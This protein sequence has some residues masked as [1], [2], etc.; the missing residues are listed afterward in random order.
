MGLKSRRT[1]KDAEK[2]R[3]GG[4]FLPFSTAVLQSSSL[5]NLSYY[6]AKLLL[7][8]ASQYKFGHNDDQSAAW[9]LMK[10]RGWRSKATLNKALSEL[11]ESGLIIMTRQGGMGRCSLFGLG[12]LAIDP[13]KGKLDIA[14]TSS[15]INLWGEKFVVK[16][17]NKVPGTSRV[18][19]C[20]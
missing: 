20:H 5:A 16:N 1:R 13:C 2:A 7:D 15:P 17:N 4:T 14:A 11:R 10:E 9:T 19:T 18:P 3:G 8:I 12:W 6:A